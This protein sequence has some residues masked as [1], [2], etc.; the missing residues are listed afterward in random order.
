MGRCVGPPCFF[1]EYPKYFTMHISH[2]LH[3]H[4]QCLICLATLSCVFAGCSHFVDTELKSH[5]SVE[6]IISPQWSL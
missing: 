3:I 6:P 5:C 1:D 4:I 2:A